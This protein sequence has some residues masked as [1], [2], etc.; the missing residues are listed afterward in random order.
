MRKALH[1]SVFATTIPLAAATLL[2]TAPAAAATAPL[3]GRFGGDARALHVEGSVGQILLLVANGA[4]EKC[5]CAG[6]HGKTE[7]VTGPA[8]NGGALL[9]ATATSASSYTAKGVHAAVVKESSTVTN[10]SLLGGMITADLL[11]GSASISATATKFTPSASVS[12]TNLVVAG[13]TVPSTVPDNTSIP[14]PGI[15][16]VTVNAVSTRAGKRIADAHAAVLQI[17]VAETNTFGLPVGATISLGEAM[18]GF[19]RVQP[20]VVLGGAAQGLKVTGDAGSGLSALARSGGARIGNCTGTAGKTITNSVTNL[21]LPGVLSLGTLVETAYGGPQGKSQEAQTSSK[22]ENLSLLGGLITADVV[23]AEATET[24]SGA[25]G[26]GSTSGTS[27]G[28]LVV[29]GVPI[30]VDV[31]ANTSLPLPL[32]GTV[33]VNEQTVTPHGATAVNALHITITTPNLLNLPVGA[34]IIVGHALATA[35]PF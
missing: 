10:L 26:K 1:T 4:R 8:I 15:G 6:T 3:P 14:L 11:Q 19:D 2:A 9:T 5:A 30:P 23:T 35:K 27:F 24:S 28:N 20:T 21:N 22:I 29:A 17:K 12:F 32:L 13:Q 25:M 31:P 33:V 7:T 34:Q 18:A 16:S